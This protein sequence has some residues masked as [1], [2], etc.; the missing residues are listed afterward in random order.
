MEERS[1]KSDSN[2]FTPARM[3]SLA[4]VI[5]NFGELSDGSFLS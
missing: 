3:S 2:V 1:D 5:F 4:G